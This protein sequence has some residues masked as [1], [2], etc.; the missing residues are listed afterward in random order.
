M[1]LHETFEASFAF[2][3]RAH[4][5]LKSLSQNELVEKVLVRRRSYSAEANSLRVGTFIA[6][7]LNGAG[8]FV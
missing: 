5:S 3:G 1:S 4:N 6:L 2:I 7:S 8:L